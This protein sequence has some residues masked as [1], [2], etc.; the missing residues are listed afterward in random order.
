[1]TASLLQERILKARRS[2]SPL[3][4]IRSIPPDWKS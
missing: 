2:F 3:R 1:M 4:T